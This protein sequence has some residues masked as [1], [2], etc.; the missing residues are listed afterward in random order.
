ME[1]LSFEANFLVAAD[2]KE[3]DTL[4]VKYQKM[5]FVLFSFRSEYFLSSK[6][7]KEG[8]KE[9]VYN[10]IAAKFY[11]NCLDLHKLYLQDHDRFLQPLEVLGYFFTIY[12]CRNHIVEV[13]ISDAGLIACLN[14][15]EDYIML[16]KGSIETLSYL[17]V[18]NLYNFAKDLNNL[19]IRDVR[20][21]PLGLNVSRYP[22][23]S[24]NV[25]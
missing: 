24:L 23:S 20:I 17:E 14:F 19:D 3:E 25:Y 2:I 21:N 10:I 9:N 11:N 15:I 5:L 1:V 18:F 16:L 13:Y 6:G 22:K 4:I 7:N 8:Y 12:P